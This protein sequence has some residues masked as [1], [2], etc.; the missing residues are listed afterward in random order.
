MEEAVA[1]GK[2][3]ALRRAVYHVVSNVDPEG[4]NLRDCVRRID[5]AVRLEERVR[6]EGGGVWDGIWGIRGSE[7]WLVWS[8]CT[9]SVQTWRSC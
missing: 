4:K 9:H 8:G 3:G 1:C 5:G 2:T 6:P 7:G